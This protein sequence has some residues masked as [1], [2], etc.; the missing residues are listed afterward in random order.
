MFSS[1]AALLGSAGQ[2]SYAAANSG[3]DAAAAASRLAGLPV[4]AV[5]W[6]PWADAG[7]AAQGPA[8]SARLQRLGFG[9][10]S[11]QSGL[12]ALQRVMAGHSCGPVQVAASLDWPALLRARPAGTSAM[13]AE[14]A[15]D[16]REG[17]Q[18]QPSLVGS[19]EHVE[20]LTYPAQRL[21]RSTRPIAPGSHHQQQSGAAEVLAAVLDVAQSLTGVLIAPHESVVAAGLD[22]LGALELRNA[23]SER[24]GVPLPATLAFDYPTPS[25]IAEY[26]AKLI[27]APLLLHAASAQPDIPRT[28]SSGRWRDLTAERPVTAVRATA[29]RLPH[30][31]FSNNISAKEVATSVP[32]EVSVIRACMQSRTVV[33]VQ[34]TAARILTQHVHAG[35]LHA[36]FTYAPSV[37]ASC[38]RSGGTLSVSTTS[39][40][41]LRSLSAASCC[42]SRPPSTAKPSAWPRTRPR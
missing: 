41:R 39:P 7:M 38:L 17:Y 10:L 4:T 15:D 35:E 16:V 24:L 23:L 5:Q 26:V 20:A 25:A 19:G 6:G 13:F 33:P 40:D 8:A 12:S 37:A 29:S 30:A 27:R 1:V 2:A 31:V 36:S 22:S 34:C 21:R 18:L 28:L 9:M 11:A 14:M 42:A 32:F 3:L